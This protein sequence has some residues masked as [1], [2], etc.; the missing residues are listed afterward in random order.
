MVLVNFYV[1][2]RSSDYIFYNVEN[3]PEAQAA[4]VLGA[5]VY[6]DGDL[7]DV[8]E[9]RAYGA[10]SLYNSGKV[11]KILMSGDHGQ[12]DYDEVNAVKAYL[13]EHGVEGE[14]IFL[15]HAGFDTYD[16]LYRAKHIFDVESLIVVTQEFHLSRG[17]YLGNGMGMETYGYVADRQPYLGITRYEVREIAARSKSFSDLFFGAESKFLGDV[18]SIDGDGRS[19][20]D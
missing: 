4:L 19:T 9:D 13:L 11:D 6:S 15:D 20:W 8:L 5:F 2:W 7:S 3:V 17:V 16:S 14:D 12:E 10:I 1:I 18:I